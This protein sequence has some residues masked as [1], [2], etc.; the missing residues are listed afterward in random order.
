M[1]RKLSRTVP[2]PRF[3]PLPTLLPTPAFSVTVL[4]ETATDK[5]IA[6]HKPAGQPATHNS[7]GLTAATLLAHSRISE[8]GVYGAFNRWCTQR[9]TVPTKRQAAKFLQD[10]PVFRK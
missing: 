1:S 7:V 5:R 9:K 8:H 2:L 6:I 3:A 10:F 4:E